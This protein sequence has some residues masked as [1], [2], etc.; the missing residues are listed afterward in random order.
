MGGGEFGGYGGC[1]NQKSKIN[2]QNRGI[3]SDNF[4]Y[5]RYNS[6]FITARVGGIPFLDVPEKS[7]FCKF[8]RNCKLFHL[9]IDFENSQKGRDN[10]E[11]SKMWLILTKTK[12][13]FNRG[14]KSNGN[15]ESA[16]RNIEIE[17]RNRKWGFEWLIIGRSKSQQKIDT[18][19]DQ[20]ADGAPE[21]RMFRMESCV[22]K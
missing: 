9:E 12:G 2:E 14:R 4:G 8:G 1:G 22:R 16:R 18:Q 21:D 11:I 19:I 15:E 20:L 10:L 13:L 3:Q 7:R 5:E 6:E 17:E